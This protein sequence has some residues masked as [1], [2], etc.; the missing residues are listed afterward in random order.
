MDELLR[1]IKKGKPNKAPG[2][3][4]ISLDFFQKTIDLTKRDLLT[5]MNNMYIDGQIT[6]NQKR[7]ILVCIPK[8]THPTKYKNTDL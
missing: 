4:R 3:D 6:E 1:A 8:T 5:I 7:G 2:Q